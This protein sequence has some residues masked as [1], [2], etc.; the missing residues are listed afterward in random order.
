MATTRTGQT[1]KSKDDEHLRLARPNLKTLTP[2]IPNEGSGE[3]LENVSTYRLT[4]PT[5]YVEP[6]ACVDCIAHVRIQE[7]I[8]IGIDK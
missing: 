2:V 3:I 7:S 1:T 8:K 4:S 5:T 6:V